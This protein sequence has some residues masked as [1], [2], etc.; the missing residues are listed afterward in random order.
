MRDST[1][2]RY[3]RIVL[4]GCALQQFAVREAIPTAIANRLYLE[5]GSEKD[6]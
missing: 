4:G 5:L 2:H 3:Q 6:T 1:I